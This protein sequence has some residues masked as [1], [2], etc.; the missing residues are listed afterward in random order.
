MTTRERED[1]T[2]PWV[3]PVREPDPSVVAPP[4]A[5]LGQA[6]GVLVLG[7][8]AFTAAMVFG[9]GVLVEDT[10]DARTDTAAEL[11][12]DGGSEPALP[13]P[14]VNGV[15]SERTS[16]TAAATPITGPE[17][18]SIGAAGPDASPITAPTTTS[19]TTTTSVDATDTG[20]VPRLSSSFDGGWVAQLTS[21]SQRS[22][23]ERLEQ[24]WQALRSDVPDAVVAVSVVLAAPWL[25]GVRAPGSVRFVGGGGLVL[26]QRRRR[27]HPARAQQLSRVP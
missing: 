6:V 21:I 2:P 13:D 26:P 15:V 24:A 12:D 14:E 19:S 25:L 7:V 8:V 4:T 16:T 23:V 5:G 18:E 17:P 20:S 22:G 1:D 9:A 11:A 27:L 3:I 10:E